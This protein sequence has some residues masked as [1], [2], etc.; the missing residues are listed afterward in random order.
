MSTTL[1]TG[2]TGN[3]ADHHAQAGILKL[4]VFRPSSFNPFVRRNVRS[5]RY[6]WRVSAASQTVAESDATGLVDARDARRRA[7]EAARQAAHEINVDVE[8]LLSVPA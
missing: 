2:W 3:D 6:C 5:E 8:R 1:P 4:S 7:I